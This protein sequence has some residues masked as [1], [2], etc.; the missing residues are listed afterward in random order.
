MH[1]VKGGI[2]RSHL[3][4]FFPHKQLTLLIVSL[5]SN[6][7]PPILQLPKLPKSESI[8][9]DVA[10]LLKH[11][12]IVVFL[13]YATLA[14]V[15]DSFII[16]FMF[17]YLE[18]LALLSGSMPHVKL[19]EGLVIAAETLGGEVIFFSY[20]GNK[21]NPINCLREITFAI[22]SSKIFLCPGKIIEKL[23]YENCL[24]LSFIFYAL[25]LGL[26][27]WVNNPW[28]LLPTE[29]FLQGPS[30]ALCYTTIVA[31][32]SAVAPPG[33]S[34]TMQGLVAGM[35]DGF[36]QFLLILMVQ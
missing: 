22:N 9:R 27:S 13:I 17:W 8:V 20:A 23:G 7:C 2:Q 5:Y 12:H 6:V 30:F 21:F 29:F 35:D 31:Y 10:S 11:K 14:G 4:N 33:T 24:S 3:I 34:A 19:I 1:K 15:C 36:G 18:D 16:Y 28:F 25:R 26:I 32:A